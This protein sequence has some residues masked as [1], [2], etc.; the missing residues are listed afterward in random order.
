MTVLRSFLCGLALLLAFGMANAD[1]QSQQAGQASRTNRTLIA[2]GDPS[3]S[4]Q[5]PHGLCQSCSVNCASGK[6]AVCI[7]GREILTGGAPRCG[8]QP[9]CACR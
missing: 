7:P 8:Q 6:R 3:C 9:M 1:A 2:P 4:W 5:S